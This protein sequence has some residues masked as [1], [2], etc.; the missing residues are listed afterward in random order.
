MWIERFV[1]D[2]SKFTNGMERISFRRDVGSLCVFYSLLNG[3]CSEEVFELMP[4]LDACL[5]KSTGLSFVPSS[6][7]Y[8]V[9]WAPTCALLYCDMTFFKKRINGAIK[10]SIHRQQ[11]NDSSA[12][13]L[14][15]KHKKMFATGMRTVN[16][17]LRR[18][19]SPTSLRPLLNQC[20]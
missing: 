1:C 18:N 17:P 9:E 4:I 8:D 15:Y 6:N 16:L 2:C 3:E 20:S 14:R 5:P 19:H 10:D 13:L 11:A 12:C 7:L